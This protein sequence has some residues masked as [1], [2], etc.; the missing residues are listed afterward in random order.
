MSAKDVYEMAEERIDKGK[1]IG[2]DY[3]ERMSAEDVSRLAVKGYKNGRSVDMYL[4][5][6]DSDGLNVI[7]EDKLLKGKPY[8]R[9]LERMGACAAYEFAVKSIREEKFEISV[10]TAYAG[11]RYGK[12]S[13]NGI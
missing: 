5:Y 9:Y 13:N 7:A 11:R 3:L 1:S 6:M 12:I 10:F 8:N 2:I 4:E